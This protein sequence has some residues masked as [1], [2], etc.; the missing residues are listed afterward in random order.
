MNNFLILLLLALAATLEAGGD[1]IARTALH[2]QAVP[3]IRLGL[4]AAAALVLFVYG[5]TVNLP[6][7]DFG[8][9]LGVY[10]S[11]FFV[12]AQL[13]NF[14]AFGMKPGMPVLAGGALILSGGLL[15][16]FWKA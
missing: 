1:A 5:V 9:L 12:V 14:F 15:M 11:L 8:K 3:L 13:I 7:W 6:P 10:V 4:F 2:S 16:T